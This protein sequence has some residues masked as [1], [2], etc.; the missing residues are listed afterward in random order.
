[1]TSKTAESTYLSFKTGEVNLCMQKP[2]FLLTK[3]RSA[4]KTFREKK[5]DVSKGIRFQMG[6]IAISVGLQLQR[7]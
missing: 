6:K 4:R 1:M 2:H 7:I 3:Q 5:C